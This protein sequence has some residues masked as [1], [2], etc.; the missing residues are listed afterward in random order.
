MKLK[1]HRRRKEHFLLPDGEVV[2]A[3]RQRRPAERRELQERNDTLIS[4]LCAGM[5]NRHAALF[6]SQTLSVPSPGREDEHFYTTGV[7]VVRRENAAL[8]LTLR[9]TSQ[10]G[11]HPVAFRSRL[12][13]F[14]LLNATRAKGD[15][16]LT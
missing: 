9:V 14:R 5:A 7:L 12:V 10:G 8:T 4:A 11:A 13:L 2:G 15:V 1:N 6:T 16:N 3:G